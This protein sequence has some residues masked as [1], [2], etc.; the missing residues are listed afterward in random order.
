MA[1]RT[2][3]ALVLITVAG[4][5]LRFYDL[6][7]HSVW[8]DEQVSITASRTLADAVRSFTHP[9][10]P[11][12]ALH[13]WTRLFGE[14]DAAFRSL[15]AVVGTLC[16]PLM[17]AT[18]L[19]AFRSER[20][21]LTAALLL[22]VLPQSIWHARQ[23][24]HYTLW[25]A[26]ALLALW[27]LLA[28]RDRTVSRS[29]TLGYWAWTIVA[30]ATHYYTAF[31]ATAHAL[32]AWCLIGTR[33]FVKTRAERRR[34]LVLHVPLVGV[35]AVLVVYRWLSWGRIGVDSAS[36]W[37]GNVTHVGW[38]LAS[39][40]F[41][42]PWAFPDPPSEAVRWGA[43]L[44]AIL[45]AAIV[46]MAR[47]RTADR[48]TLW[49]LSIVL[50][51]P[52]FAIE[53]LPIRSYTRLLTPTLSL[54][55]LWLAYAACAPLASRL[56]QLGRVIVAVV[57]I[58]KLVPYIGTVYTLEI[59]PWN[60]VCAQIAAQETAHTVVLVNEPYMVPTLRHC[61][62]AT[63]PV[64]RFPSRKHALDADNIVSF[65]APYDE[66]WLVYSH[67][68][69][70]DPRRRGVRALLATYELVDRRSYG[71]LLATFHL[72]RRPR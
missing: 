27:S 70:T 26:F 23:I 60:T 43:F 10:V 37:F 44:A 6:G 41:F 9:P 24:R 30:M 17:F 69:H 13:L 19:R 8:L 57:L 45:L 40:V 4:G 47:D 5:A 66:V 36:T 7:A 35:A 29:A 58:V 62:V 2:G 54:I 18:A 38:W 56:A 63:A 67:A 32:A 71:P 61:Y 50:W 21:A 42:R 48:R 64:I 51:L 55:V 11:Y 20:V 31:Y 3:W 59:E 34:W 46:A 14:S 53:L 12:V 49:A 28:Q 15:A 22:A 65:T 68:W 72:R 52:L 25:P 1:V 33:P 16:I 39:L